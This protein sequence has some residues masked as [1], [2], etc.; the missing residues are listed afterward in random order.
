MLILAWILHTTLAATATAAAAAPPAP[1]VVVELFTSQGCSSC[2]PADR[3]LREL[4]HEPGVIALSF[5]VDYWN[6]LGWADPFSSAEWSRRQSEYAAAFDRAGVYTPQMV[7]AGADEMV[8]SD[9]NRVRRAIASARANATEARVAITARVEGGM[10][11]AEARVEIENRDPSKHQLILL[12]T[13]SGLIT[14]VARGENA[15]STSAHDFVVRRLLRTPLT[16]VEGT[17]GTMTRSFDLD[18]EWRAD[19]LS[20]VALIQDPRSGRIA[21]AAFASP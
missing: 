4:G 21:G 18:S 12:V 2:P 14:A 11:V 13:E 7:V 10:L 15:G 19:R 16:A 3:L 6:R 5:H 1:P 17:T 8:G 20:V 9:E